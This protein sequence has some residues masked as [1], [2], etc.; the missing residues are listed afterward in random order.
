MLG[1]PN[2]FQ[3]LIPKI[4]FPNRLSKRYKGK[5]RIKKKNNLS[6]PF[7]SL[8]LKQ[9]ETRLGFEILTSVCQIGILLCRLSIVK[10]TYGPLLGPLM[11]RILPH[12]CDVQ[13][14]DQ[15]RKVQNRLLR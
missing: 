13:N 15:T 6:L 5:S 14:N 2:L 7:H 10:E 12:T 8:S 4:P 11:I 1:S 3:E 9:N